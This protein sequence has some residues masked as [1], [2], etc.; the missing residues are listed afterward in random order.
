MYQKL[1]GRWDTST[2]LAKLLKEY[3]ID[4]S[5]WRQTLPKVNDDD[6]EL[7]PTTDRQKKMLELRK[8]GKT[9]NEIAKELNCSKGSISYFFRKKTRIS[10]KKRKE[11]YEP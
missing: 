7:I 5:H 3:N 9:F 6:L 10:T 4:I 1:S 2:K 11:K 8:Q